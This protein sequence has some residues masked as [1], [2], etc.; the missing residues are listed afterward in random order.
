[1][2]KDTTLA[3]IV[4]DEEENPAWGVRTWLEATLPYVEKAVII[5]TGSVDKTRKILNEIAIEFGNLEIYRRKFDDFASSRNFSISKVKTKR[6]LV[7]DADEL[8]LPEEYVRLGIYIKANE[9][10][11]YDLDFK[12]IYFDGST[13]NTDINVQV[14]RIFDMDQAIRFENQGNKNHYEYPVLPKYIDCPIIPKHVAIIKH[15]LPP[16]E[17]KKIKSSHWYREEDLKSFTPHEHSTMYGWKTRNPFRKY[18]FMPE[19]EIE[20]HMPKYV[21]KQL[22]RQSLYKE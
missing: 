10:R 16:Q 7:L 21:E 11:Y 20:S 12:L 1:M 4:R 22:E 9:K 15:F 13:I 18:F 5:D 8:L 14:T 19:A 2:L 3:A 6:A 17:A